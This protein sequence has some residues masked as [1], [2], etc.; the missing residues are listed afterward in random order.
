MSETTPSFD[1]EIS[2]LELDQA[3]LA[4]LAKTSYAEQHH[5][6]RPD[7]G[8]SVWSARD[9][10]GRD[11]TFK[12]INHRDLEK[13]NLA[14]QFD[15]HKLFQQAGVRVPNVLGL[16]TGIELAG[17]AAQVLATETVKGRTL[18]EELRRRQAAHQP[19]T[20]DELQAI[21]NDAS[22]QVRRAHAADLY[23]R[24]LDLRNVMLDEHG[25]IVFLDFGR[26]KKALAAEDEE[27]IYREPV[28]RSGRHVTAQYLRDDAFISSFVTKIRQLGLFGQKAA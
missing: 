5:Q 3:Q 20:P 13:N 28:T 16:L 7:I 22:E 24:D 17:T 18:E 1:Q 14:K 4:D 19:F 26:A 23:H 8:S 11:I 21:I 15:L 9:Q 12:T 6:S 27:D 25:R 2:R 10:A